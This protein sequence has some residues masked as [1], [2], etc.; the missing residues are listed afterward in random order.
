MKPGVAGLPD[1]G[2][3]TRFNAL[4][5]R[6]PFISDI[7]DYLSGRRGRRGENRS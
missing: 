2:K 1:A 7:S 4:A 5:G 3:T 6:G